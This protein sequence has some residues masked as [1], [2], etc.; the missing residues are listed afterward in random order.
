[1][2]RNIEEMKRWKRSWILPMPTRGAT[3]G[4]HQLHYHDE[5]LR[6]FGANPK[7][8]TGLFAPLMEL[9]GHYESR[10]YAEIVSGTW[11]QQGL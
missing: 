5:L 8:K 1:M 6:D 2:V 10:D 11:R 9:I 7:R 3:I 4:P